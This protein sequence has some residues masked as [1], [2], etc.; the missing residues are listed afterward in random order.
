MDQKFHC[1]ALVPVMLLLAVAEQLRR[2]RQAGCWPDA[3]HAGTG[4][5]AARAFTARPGQLALTLADYERGP[6]GRP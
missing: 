1:H 3:E 4:I 2:L 5:T 6:P